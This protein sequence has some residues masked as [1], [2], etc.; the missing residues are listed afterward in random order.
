MEGRTSCHLRTD[1]PLIS[2]PPRTDL[3]L[4][5]KIRT[6]PPH[7]RTPPPYI[8]TAPPHIRTPP[9]YIRTAPPYIRTAPPHIK[10]APP[11]IRTLLIRTL[12]SLRYLLTY[13]CTYPVITRLSTWDAPPF[14][15]GLYC[16]V[17]TYC[18]EHYS[19]CD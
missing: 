6:A 10:T 12:Q 17:L 14:S 13:H 4:L 3:Q 9:P 7:I 16:V 8:R 1:Q 19:N 18:G 2:L 5:L 15:D 11:H